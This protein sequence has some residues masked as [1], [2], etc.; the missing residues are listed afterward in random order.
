MPKKLIAILFAAA[1][2]TSAL[3]QAIDS[4]PADA[5]LLVDTPG[6]SAA[7]L[8]E[9]GG[10]LAAF[11]SARQDIDTQLVLTASMHPTALQ[12]TADLYQVFRPAKL[13]FTRLDETGSMASAF[14][15]AARLSK[16]LSFFSTG[17]LIPEDLEPA[18]REKIIAAL[19]R[20]LPLA[21]EA[22][23]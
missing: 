14:C 4:A 21:L 3:A 17:Q 11:L 7:A 12:R 5:L 6:Y 19:V 23:A 10:D 16:R 18:S 1:I 9:S 13:L 20:E 15:E 22:V 8:Q 2:A